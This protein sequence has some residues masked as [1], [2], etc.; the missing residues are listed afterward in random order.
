MFRKVIL[1]LLL[2]GVG[3][4]TAVST[5]AAEPREP[6]RPIQAW[7]LDE[8]LAQLQL[9]PQDS[10]FQYVALQ[11]A[12]RKGEDELKR[13]AGLIVMR[14]RRALARRGAGRG[15]NVDLLRMTTGALAVQ[16]S[17]QLDA[18]ADLENAAA[19]V[20][21]SRS[22]RMF[23]GN[24]GT[25]E[26]LRR[27]ALAFHNYHDTY[28]RFPTTASYDS[29]G[30]PLLS[31]RVHV[32]PYLGQRELFRQF[33]LD[34]PWDSPAN[35]QLIARMPE[36][37]GL[38]GGARDRQ[39]KTRYLVPVGDATLF[40]GSEPLRIADTR[41]GTSNTIMIVEAAPAEAVIWTKPD[42]L[43]FDQTY[44][45]ET[46]VL[47]LIDNSI[48]SETARVISGEPVLLDRLP[49]ARRDIFS[50]ALKFDKSQLIQIDAAEP[51]PLQVINNLKQI[52]L[53]F[54]NYHDVHKRFPPALEK[55]SGL[56]W[57]VHLLPFLE[58]QPLYDEF[59]LDEPWD[60]AH[61]KKLLDSMPNMYGS[62][63]TKTR[64]LGFAGDGAPMG[65]SRGLSFRDIR[66]GTSNTLLVVQAG[67]DRAVPWTK[68]ED[69]AFN[70]QDPRGALGQI[71][72]QGIPA[73]MMDGSVHTL[74]RDIDAARL[75]GL[76]TYRGR[77]IVEYPGRTAQRSPRPMLDPRD[78][79][80]A[81]QEMG[82]PAEDTEKLNV[83]EFLVR[84]IGDELSF[85]MC[86]SE[87]T[88][89]FSVPRFL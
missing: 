29:Q 70:P 77:E 41:D 88:F 57:R 42:D 35:K 26:N 43:A 79:E 37:Y 62:E 33:R 75:S 36:I 47:P 80:R 7:T 4:M 40:K 65:Q 63:G 73:L 6:G 48:Y 31:W 10:Y 44:R 71:G 5:Q 59:H 46:I 32:L 61:N 52:G 12:R 9:H 45:L 78:I 20:N 64:M 27:L 72:E 22:V 16:E 67:P 24:A 84:G 55:H 15:E 19:A 66:D 53:A 3:A 69:L 56:S 2:G 18:M 58:Q 68:P 14:G 87:P 54:H 17:L 76:I 11:L 85:H 82:V 83:A 81:P 23:R 89:S 51:R 60:S 50:L 1:T 8:A 28:K 86:D 74:P 13:V 21:R 34:E 39:H 30:K 38:S 49:V 25:Q